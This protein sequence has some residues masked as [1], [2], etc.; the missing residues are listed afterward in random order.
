MN[1]TVTAPLVCALTVL[2]SMLPVLVAPAF[3]QPPAAGGCPRLRLLA[4]ADAPGDCAAF[5]QER[6]RSDQPN[7]PAAAATM[8]G[9]MFGSAASALSEVPDRDFHVTREGFFGRTTYAGGADKA[10]HFA[11]YAILSK[12]LA[13]L[14]GEL[15]F[16]RRDAIWLGFG[17]ALTAGLVTELGDG[18]SKFG[19]SYEDLLMDGL[20][21]GTAALLAA[22]GTQDLVGFRYGFL[23]PPSGSA[24]C[25]K[26]EGVGRDYSNELYTA[27]LKLAGL[28]RRLRLDVGPLRS[29]LLST[30]Y[31]SKS[32]PTGLPE[33]RQRQVGIEIGL[34]VEQILNDLG[35][36]RHTWWGYGLHL[37]FDNVRFPFTS[38][39]FRYDLN[40][41]RWRGPDNGHDF[42]P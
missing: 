9:S 1:L 29:L 7:W 31:G 15:G 40:R 18:F 32:Y 5:A 36:G 27:D 23:L 4:S 30:T 20:G 6:E 33:R 8:V 2:V 35:I 22:T 19:F 11:Q 34:N 26:V 21:A 28:A 17:V 13:Y 39:G 14:Y 38:I 37:V 16:T 41:G 3:G 24:T 10:S 12:E 42:S 25:C